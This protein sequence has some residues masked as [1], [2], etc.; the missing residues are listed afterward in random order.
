MGD[1]NQGK[2]L[3]KSLVDKYF[4]TMKR[5]DRKDAW[6]LAA[7][8]VAWA[9]VFTIPIL[10]AW[11]T[12]NSIDVARKTGMMLIGMLFSPFALYFLNFYLLGPF[13]YFKRRWVLFFGSN[14]AVFTA[15]NYG[16]YFANRFIS[17]LPLE[18]RIGSY[19]GFFVFFLFNV[20]CIA[21]AL[22]IRHLI[23][24][25]RINQQLEEE[26]AKNLEAELAWLKSQINPHFL[27]NTLNNISSLTQ[28]DPDSAQEALAQ[29]SDLLRYAM[30]ETQKEKVPLK[31]EV[32]FMTNYVELMRLRCSETT[33]ITTRFDVSGNTEV[34]PLLFISLVENAFK[35]GVSNTVESSIDISMEEKEGLLTFTCTNTNHPKSQDDRSGSGIGLENTRRRLELLYP[36]RYTR[37]QTLENNIYHVSV[38]IDLRP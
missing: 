22:V 21:L 3:E 28:I 1:K 10:L 8:L 31:G 38:T 19:I 17:H 20:A 36:G 4:S 37:S 26:K 15:L 12:S 32:A 18:A 14:I 13:L 30:Y 9:L 24:V 6:V 16:I 23:R 5:I 7:Q 25:G 29:L 33:H 27:F 2:T 35:H 34:A 11:L